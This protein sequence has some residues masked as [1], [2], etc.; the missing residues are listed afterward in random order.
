MGPLR[1]LDPLSVCPSPA[2][3][4]SNSQ[5]SSP[6]CTVDHPQP[7]HCGRSQSP[8]SPC[9]TLPPIPSLLPIPDLPPFTHLPSNPVFS[10][11]SAEETSVIPLLDKIYKE[12]VCWKRNLFRVP[13]GSAGKR[14]VSEMARLFF[15]YANFLSIEIISLKAALVLPS[16][17]LQR[18][19]PKSKD[20]ENI[21]CLERRLNEWSDGHLS[22][23]FDECKQIQSRLRP[24]RPYESDTSNR[25]AI[26]F[27]NLVFQGKIKDALRLL[28]SS[29]S[30][31][32]LH[33]NDS[34]GQDNLSVLDCLHSK[35]PQG[36]PI[37]SS[38]YIYPLQSDFD[39][40]PVIFEKLTGSLIKSVA[41]R[42]RGSAGPS[43]VDAAE[44]RRLCSCFKRSS[45]ELC[46]ALAAVARRL[47]SE[48]VDPAGLST[49]VASR[50]I[51]LD[52]N[53]GVRP[54]GVG[55][56]CRRIIGKAILCVIGLD[57]QEAAGSVQL[58][59]GQSG[60]CESAIHAVRSLF[61]DPESQ[62]LLMVDASNAFNSLNR[63]LALINISRL[64]PSFSKVLINTYRD[65]VSMF[66]DGEF[67]FSTEGTT[68]GD[69][70][71]MG[72]YA[73]ATIPL[74]HRLHDFAKQVW[75]ADDAAACDTLSHLRQWWDLLNDIGPSYGYFPNSRKNLRMKQ[76]PF[77]VTQWLTSLMLVI[78][79]L[80][81]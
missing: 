15:D 44:W 45:D 43:G 56:V 49:F 71:A 4:S 20:K 19:H 46:S 3:L 41:Q 2:V 12:V 35:H 25:C 29:S 50:L 55:E 72:M 36:Q 47:C 81:L 80:D 34:S 9:D 13:F 54:I 52:K 74:I 79:I 30:G 24:S 8:Y 27:A 73:L 33:L 18:P 76:N 37:L 22:I 63:Q 58:C 10:W 78:G 51:A 39:P 32:I 70:L 21:S 14:F 53:P 64:C 68:Q 62:G 7:S 1:P 11:G 23:L 5:P 66:I 38:D 48:Y 61:S 40:H 28:D 75:Y 57:I 31:R 69:P 77:L 42:T 65:P 26:A 6:P 60:G 67:I 17:L 16:L 59:A